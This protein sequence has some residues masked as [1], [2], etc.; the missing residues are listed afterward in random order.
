MAKKIVKSDNA[1][2]DKLLQSRINDAF[3][4]A[5]RYQTRFIGFLD[6]HERSV[7]KRQAQYLLVNPDY[8]GCSYAFWG[9]YAEAERAFFG[10]FPPFSEP[11]N[12]EYPITAIDITWRFTSLAHRDFL[13]ALLALGIVRG[14]IGDIVLGD[15]Q[16]TV[17]AEKTVAEFI[18]QNLE[19]VGKAGVCCK[20]ADD[21]EPV[22]EE[23]FKEIKGT[24]ASS[25]LD[26]VIS[27]L[28]GISRSASAKL[29]L[30]G[31]VSVN[32]EADCDT[33]DSISDGATVSIRGYGRFAVDQIGP[34]TKKGRFSFA[35]RK[36]L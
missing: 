20:I 15:G 26:C 6:P 8:D 4:A 2:E 17:F 7:A 27:A 3:D 35:A 9:G 29:I 1:E 30:G 24:I 25:R 21:T 5:S 18:L 19:K 31:L 13:G 33:T 22:K 12:S 14:K 34:K 10:I 23:N 28:V 32:F 11:Q 16:C 36:Y